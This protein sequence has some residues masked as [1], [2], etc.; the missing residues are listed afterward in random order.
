MGIFSF[1]ENKNEKQEPIS[2]S[3]RNFIKK[4]GNTTLNV[5]ALGALSVVSNRSETVD[6]LDRLRGIFL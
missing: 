3:R 2:Q 6:A 1:K 5:I 4:T